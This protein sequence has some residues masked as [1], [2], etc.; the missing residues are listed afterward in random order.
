[1][2][3]VGAQ[4][5]ELLAYLSEL[6]LLLLEASVDAGEAFPHLL[7]DLAELPPSQ[8]AEP[9]GDDQDENG[10]DDLTEGHIPHSRGEKDP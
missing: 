5:P 6:Q 4:R 3:E 10:D 1:V 9:S 7:S 2:G 8:S